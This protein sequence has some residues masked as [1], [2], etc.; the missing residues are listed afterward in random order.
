MAFVRYSNT[1]TDKYGNGL[2]GATVTV[3]VQPGLGNS[4]TTLAVLYSNST[5]TPLSNPLTTDTLGNYDFYA[6]KGAYTILV[7]KSGVTYTDTDIF[8]DEPNLDVRMFGAKC[9]GV[10]DDYVA[11]SAAI[12]AA[13]AQKGFVVLPAGKTLAYGTALTLTSSEFGIIGLGGSKL[14]YTGNGTDAILIDG[15]GSTNGARNVVLRDFIIDAP[16]AV[17]GLHTIKY[18]SSEVSNVRVTGCTGTAFLNEFAVASQFSHVITSVNAAAFSATPTN[19]FV[20]QNYLGTGSSDNLVLNPVIEGVSG[21]GIQLTNANG[22]LILG[23]TSEACGGRGVYISGNSQYNTLMDVDIEANTG[24]DIE[25]ASTG[26]RHT[27][28]LNCVIQDDL[29]INGAPKETIVDGGSYGTITILA[30]ALATSIINGCS[31]GTLNDSGTNTQLVGLNAQTVNKLQ[32]TQFMSNPILTNDKA[33]KAYGSSGV[34]YPLLW[35]TAADQTLLQYLT[36]S[37]LKVRNTDGTAALNCNDSGVVVTGSLSVGTA[38]VL[39]PTGVSVGSRIV[40]AA[41][42]VNA[43]S[44]S[45]NQTSTGDYAI[46]N[47]FRLG[48]NPTANST[49]FQ[50]GISAEAWINAGNTKTF[51]GQQ[52]GTYGSFSHFGSGAASAIYGG[53]FEGFNSGSATVTQICGVNGNAWCGGVAAGAPLQTPTNNGAATNLRG[54]QAF[55]SNLSSGVVGTAQGVYVNTATNTG[56][57][58][59]T[60]VV[61]VDVANQTAGG[62]NFAIRTAFGTVKFGDTL[63]IVGHNTLPAATGTTLYIGSGY[64]SPIAGKIYIGDGTG[65]QLNMSKRSGSVDTELFQFKDSGDFIASASITGAKVSG[66]TV[67]ST[68]AAP[69]I[70]AGVLTLDCSTGNSFRINLNANVTSMSLTNPTDGQVITILWVQDATGSRT[71]SMAANLKGATAPSAGINTRSAQSFI[72]DSTTTNWYATSAASTGM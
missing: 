22:T 29:Y 45:T 56:A 59:I 63:N 15:H 50:M 28:L 4:S 44:L 38:N 46:P 72:Y 47:V 49:Q 52:T 41:G 1:A 69:A 43:H 35:W 55:T 37:Q 21:D 65:W 20:I 70:S 24:H 9:D 10:T 32:E 18:V 67:L 66:T 48:I 36:G 19:G 16:S 27:K 58:S 54:V 25:L 53:S 42:D 13:I 39:D 11:L 2:S 68:K 34:Q 3:Y 30:G 17:N 5:G 40:S 71:V 57:G 64:S 23:G 31:Y 60:T 33:L 12:T 14:K 61:G 6:A 51:S 8:I 7:T 26:C 62:T